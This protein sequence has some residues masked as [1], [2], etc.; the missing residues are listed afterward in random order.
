MEQPS[1]IVMRQISLNEID[2]DAD[3][4]STCAGD[5]DDFD[6]NV[7]GLQAVVQWEPAWTSWEVN[8]MLEMMCTP[9]TL[10]R[11]CI[12]GIQCLL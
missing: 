5:C 10:R 6:P 8:T 7:S 2:I 1:M 9:S 3:G 11:R 4:N 12:H